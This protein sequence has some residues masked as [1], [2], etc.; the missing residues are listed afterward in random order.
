MTPTRSEPPLP[1]PG[2]APRLGPLD[3]LLFA[4][5]CGL[6]GGELEVAARVVYRV[7]S[8]TN[9][10][11]LM[12]RHFVWL[13][14]LINLA[15]FV[16]VG[17][18][19]AMATR[20]W[21]RRAGWWSPRLIL[22]W[23]LLPGLALAGRSIYVEAW[24]LVAVGVASRLAP[25]LEQRPG[26]ARRLMAMS[27]PVLLGLVAVQAG[28]AVG[29]DRMWRWDDGGRPLPPAGS[30]NVL[31]V[32]LDTVR[33]DHLSLY[34]YQRST[35]PRLDRLAGRGI[36]FD[37]ARASAPW[38]LASHANMFT[39][40]WPHELGVEWNC[41]P[42]TEAP[43][44]A[45]HL[46]SIGYATAGFAGNTFYCSYD[47][48]LDR[49][50]GHYEDHV[51]DWLGAARTDRTL[52]EVLKLI[53]GLGRFLPISYRTSLALSEGERKDAATVNREFLGWLS[54]RREPGRPFFAFLNYVDAHAPYLLP[55][56]ARS[57]F[58]PAPMTEAEMRFL[59]DDWT[60][61][62]RRRFP[63]A[64]RRLVRDAYDNCLAYLDDRVGDLID[65]LRDRGVLDQTLIIV[66]ADHGEG[67]GEHE[68]FEHGE[69]LYRTEIRVP[70]LIVLPAGRDR[71]D[72]PAVVD[73]PVSLRDIAATVADFV[74]PGAE[75]PFPGRSLLR[76]S[77]TRATA[78]AGRPEGGDVVLSEL[79]SP[80]PSDPNGGRSPA[81]RGPLVALA[82][83]PLVYI[84]NR[85]DGT[86]ELFNEGDDPDET[87][88]LARDEAMGPVL[89]RFRERARRASIGE[90][91]AGRGDAGIGTKARKTVGLDEP[92]QSRDI[93]EATPAELLGQSP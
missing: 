26:T 14:P 45:E 77:G 68:L 51:L 53:G 43:T 35:T 92:H 58:G 32:V 34:G 13:V 67:L 60:E 64:A 1:T 78:A 25:A 8:S 30:P 89:E 90:A 27:L 74:R 65:D 49:G 28:W 82:E 15:V 29:A 3:V 42:R 2:S 93:A 9:R 81:R 80:N 10:L 17:A 20:R 66:T 71:S 5:W 70:L 37:R 40:R 88:N 38:T 7:F 83:G 36:R 91:G 56:G 22:A 55:P 21:P 6:A 76:F 46:G 4:A 44:L 52:N 18:L 24:L 31:L 85:G 19:L 16:G 79:A 61:A 86:E 72:S 73:T 87:S 50:F 69:S 63:R 33:A 12:T 41:P 75:S 54:R 39:G 11:Y 84:R 57:R 23:A 59:G 48:G 47:S 62:N